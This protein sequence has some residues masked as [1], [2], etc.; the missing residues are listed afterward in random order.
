[1]RMQTQT[2]MQQALM[3]LMSGCNMYGT[4]VSMAGNESSVGDD[5]SV[6]QL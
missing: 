2:M 1:M 6:P 4:G 5:V 3:F